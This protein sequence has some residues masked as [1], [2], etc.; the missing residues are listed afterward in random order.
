MEAVGTVRN[1]PFEAKVSD[2]D[3]ELLSQAAALLV[4]KQ[5]ASL[6]MI[7]GELHVGHS[8]AVKL[9]V[10]LEVL[11]VVS[12]SSGARARSI[13]KSPE[14]LVEVLLSIRAAVRLR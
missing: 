1:S 13:L 11:G 10:E 3:S 12:P 6:S 9:M 5:T 7:Q 2:D 4:T 8:R 14:Q